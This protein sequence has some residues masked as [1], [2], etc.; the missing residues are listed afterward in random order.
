MQSD[1]HR[2]L[3]LL[4]QS[5]QNPDEADREYNYAHFIDEKTKAQ[6]EVK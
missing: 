2:D 3:Y 1:L 5:S 6:D 4:I